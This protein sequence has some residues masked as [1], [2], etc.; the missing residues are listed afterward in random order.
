MDNSIAGLSQT[1]ISQNNSNVHVAD[2]GTGAVNVYVDGNLELDITDSGLRLGGAGVR[3]NSISPG[4]VWRNQ[5]DAYY[6]R[7]VQRTPLK[8]MATEEDL[9]GAVAYLSSDLSNY[10]T[11]HN[12]VVDGGI[13][14]W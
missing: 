4:G 12:L 2:T 11:G 5:P 10:V 8:R 7:Y 9:K 14:A 13:T 3:V 6:N 1:S